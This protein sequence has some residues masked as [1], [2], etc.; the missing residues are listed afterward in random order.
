MTWTPIVGQKVRAKITMI[1]DLTHDGMGRELC[2]ERNDTLIV[3][4][5]GSG[6]LNCISVSHE[7]ITDRAFCCAPDEIE[8]ISN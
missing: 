4:Q 6:Y 7:H 2:A 5:V 8:L 1:N 3:R